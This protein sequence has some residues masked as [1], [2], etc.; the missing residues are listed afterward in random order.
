MKNLERYNNF[1]SNKD[2]YQQNVSFWNEKVRQWSDIDFVEYITTQYSNGTKFYDGNPIFSAFFKG[3]KK[4]VR[5]IQ[6]E[7]SISDLQLIVWTDKITFQDIEV[8]ELVFSIQL[9]EI[10]LSDVEYLF[11]FYISGQLKS[12]ALKIINEKYETLLFDSKK[13]D[14]QG[15][16][17]KKLRSIRQYLSKIKQEDIQNKRYDIE[18][19][20]L[21]GKLSEDIVLIEIGGEKKLLTKEIIQCNSNIKQVHSLATLKNSIN[22]NTGVD[23]ETFCKVVIN[24]YGNNHN[25]YRHYQKVNE[26]IE[27]S[28]IRLED[29]LK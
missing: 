26:Q 2:I 1:L 3:K 10:T 13:I 11:N 20:R 14:L 5:I 29:T 27:E 22:F 23:N 12:N 17:R 21:L 24:S 28:F 7:K 8:E 16:L 18:S 15:I 19:F 9:N 6:T 4:A 25:Y